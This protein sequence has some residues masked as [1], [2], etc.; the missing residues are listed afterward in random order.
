MKKIVGATIIVL[1]AACLFLTFYSF[2]IF[3]FGSVSR[4]DEFSLSAKAR[5][6]AVLAHPSW[7]IAVLGNY[8]NQAYISEF[9]QGIGR[10]ALQINMN[11]GIRGKLLNVTYVE[12][13]EDEYAVTLAV[14]KLCETPEVA[15]MLGPMSASH[16][17]L[18]RSLTQYHAMPALAPYA[19]LPPE[20]P[21]L[22]PDLFGALYP[23][24][25]LLDPMVE[26]LKALGCRNVLFV[27]LG[28]DSHSESFTVMLSEKLRDDPF[29]CEIHRIDF[30][31]P[32]RENQL[33]QPLKRIY[34]NSQIDAIIYT[35]G[36]ENL[37]VLGRVMKSLYINV[38]VF[39]NDLLAVPTLRHYVAECEFPL[40]YVT[41][42]GQIIPDDV[43]REYVRVF[44]RE[45]AIKEQLGILGC[46]LFRDA[47][48]GMPTYDPLR[49]GERIKDLSATFFAGGRAR[50]QPVFHEI[51]PAGGT[52]NEN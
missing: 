22:T 32:A 26:R 40:Y 43:A 20:L 29:F 10:A 3:N 37:R 45:P 41:F 28:T 52:H 30:Q 46:L 51:G 39:G 7:E 19:P 36:P 17:K 21:P 34:E 2:G 31:P 14:Q 5:K 48:D 18:V 27:S 15:F 38:P 16:V 49:I 25:L 44:R 4:S 50:I 12:P 13:E 33:Y 35:D 42:S 23:T 8:Q 6:R 11:G 1:V 9:A 47:V 24:Q